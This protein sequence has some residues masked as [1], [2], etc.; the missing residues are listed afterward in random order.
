MTAP[1][2]RAEGGAPGHTTRLDMWLDQIAR[3]A[4]ARKAAC[5]CDSCACRYPSF[6]ALLIRAIHAAEDENRGRPGYSSGVLST[7]PG[8]LRKSNRP[9]DPT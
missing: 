4:A 2:A 6:G 5:R 3:V 8:R 7:R 1:A 9:E